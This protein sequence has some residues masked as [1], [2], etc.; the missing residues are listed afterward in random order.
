MPLSSW[1]FPMEHVLGRGPAQP[2]ELAPFPTDISMVR[3]CEARRV[4]PPGLTLLCA[5]LSLTVA[6][7]RDDSVSVL[8]VTT[9]AAPM[10]SS[11]ARDT[12]GLLITVQVRNPLTRSVRVVTKPGR[13]LKHSEKDLVGRMMVEV[14]RASWGA[15]FAV[16]IEP[17][18][19]NGA[20]GGPVYSYP[21]PG[22]RTFTF[23]TGA[24]PFGQSVY[25]AP[26]GRTFTFGPGQTLADSFRLAFRPKPI[27]PVGQELNVNAEH[28]PYW[29]RWYGEGGLSGFPQFKAG[30]YLLH[31]SWNT[32]VGPPVEIEIRP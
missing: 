4:T 7:S 16:L 11:V 12:L 1:Q 21:A 18:D 3:S 26:E 32:K 9:T 28:N 29:I 17:M 19:S 14:G 23:G 10:V 22:G 20:A 15:G 31:G 6:C 13:Y 5:A 25:P 27:D 8:E 30:R 24:L 2:G